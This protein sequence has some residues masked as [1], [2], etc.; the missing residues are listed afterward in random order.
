MNASFYPSSV[1]GMQ[2]DM[3]LWQTM[4]SN[5]WFRNLSTSVKDQLLGNARQV[6]LAP[7]ET[8]YHKGDASG[9]IFGVVRGK[10]KVA[11][12]RRDGRETLLSIV[13]PGIWLGE[14]SSVECVPR[15]HDV[16]A[17]TQCELLAVPKQAF[18]ALMERAEFARAIAGLLATRLR[19]LYHVVDDANVTSARSRLASRLIMLAHG[20]AL[21]ATTEQRSVAVSQMDLAVMLGVTRQTMSKELRT[22]ASEGAIEVGYGRIAICSVALLKKIA[23]Q[24]T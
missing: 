17:L 20:D 10:L 4:T 16:I 6:C 22:L 9:G 11:N 3:A 23:A 21:L 1:S 15:T 8:L 24:E 5:P 18:E 2:T 13:E 19:W 12:L 14:Q 7:G